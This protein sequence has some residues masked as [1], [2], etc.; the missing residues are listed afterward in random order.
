MLTHFLDTGPNV[1]GTPYRRRWPA[2]RPWRD[3]LRHQISEPN[4]LERLA[5][6]ADRS[7]RPLDGYRELQRRGLL[8]DSSPFGDGLT[9]L[10][11]MALLLP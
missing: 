9:D 8:S 7:G 2:R 4:E 10:E 6:M 5:L 11:R 3:A 1:P